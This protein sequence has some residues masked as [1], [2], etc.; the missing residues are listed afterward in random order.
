MSSG[1]PSSH[2]LGEHYL[3]QETTEDPAKLCY[4]LRLSEKLLSSISV[5]EIM[6][7]ESEEQSPQ[8]LASIT[9]LAL[10][11]GQQVGIW[12]N[13]QN[14]LARREMAIIYLVTWTITRGF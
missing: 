8:G 13:S 2:I 5:D 3:Q 6:C 1:D 4:G 7:L 14:I 12:V 10:Q 9:H 11:S